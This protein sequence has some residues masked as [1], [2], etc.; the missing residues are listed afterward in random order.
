MGLCDGTSRW[1]SHS[2][3]DHEIPHSKHSAAKSVR[4]HMRSAIR[5]R[6][7]VVSAAAALVA[8]SASAN[9]EVTHEFSSSVPR[10]GVRSVTIEIPI[11]TLEIRNGASGAIAV[12][13]EARRE[14]DGP[15]ERVS[16]QR[17]V[18][19]SS[20]EIE[21]RGDEAFIRRRFESGAGS[22]ASGHTKFD[23]SI[24]IPQSLNV[25]IEQKVGELRM[26]GAF[27]NVDIEMRVGEV[28]IRTP[29]VNVRELTAGTTVGEVHTNV[30]DRTFD[31]EGLF[32]GK[33]HYINE[34]GKS[35][36]RVDLSIGE[37]HIQL[38]K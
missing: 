7:L 37:I 2:F 35:S 16:R 36:F 6:T 14:Y 5:F 33:T 23:V 30:G 4:P 1:D 22:W 18:D 29:K 17:A 19:S 9:R 15:Q 34:G 11:G 32:A 10:A 31:R 28:H 25:M 26:D 38:T 12:H 24:E 3:F 8:V 27:G 13:G 21:V 20:V